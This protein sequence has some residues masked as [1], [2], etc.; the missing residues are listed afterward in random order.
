MP[1]IAAA[2]G[3]VVALAAALTACAAE[4]DPDPEWTEEAAYAEAEEVFREYWSLDREEQNDLVTAE[5]LEANERGRKRIE[6][7][8]AEVRG[9]SKIES[10]EFSGFRIVGTTAV[11]ELNACIDGSDV[12]VSI[13][14]GDWKQARDDTSYGVAAQL[15]AEG[16]RMLVAD[17]SEPGA[18]AC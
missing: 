12:E 3:T 17:L 13:D 7:L 2:I 6:E 8:G 4:P 1:R 16:D 14:G 10:L 5:M 15:E 9:D 18:D 11:V